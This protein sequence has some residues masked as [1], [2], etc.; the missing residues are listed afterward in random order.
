MWVGRAAP[1][2][3]GSGRRGGS[4]SARSESVLSGSAAAGSDTHTQTGESATSR[5]R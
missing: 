3:A 1:P 2:A 5:A 4:G